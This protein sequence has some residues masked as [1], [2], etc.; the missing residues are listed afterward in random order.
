MTIRWSIPSNKGLRV[1]LL[2]IPI[3]IVF[4]VVVLLLAYIIAAYRGSELDDAATLALASSCALIAGLFFVVFHV[5]SVTIQVPCKNKQAFLRGCRAVLKDL[6]YELHDRCAEEWVS[7]PSFRSMLLGGR[8]HVD[9]R[10][11]DI[12]ITGPKVF[13]EILRHR[14]RL[15]SHVA[16][17]EQS[18]RDSRL[19]LGDHLLKR[20]Q[21]SLRVTPAQWAEVGHSVVERLAAEGA[22][23]VCEVHL[24]AH[25]GEGIRESFVEGELR[26]W[27]KKEHLVAEVHKD[28]IRWEEPLPRSEPVNLVDTK[29]EGMKCL[30]L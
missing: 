3:L 17:V 28:H 5:K 24:M 22:E 23:V 19:R 7:W 27:L 2:A 6:G 16:T 1:L 14:L 11:D 30:K 29:V 9:A 18:M 10:G 26:E 12:K 25:S 15:Q 4:A 20:V 8:L 21:I 13:V